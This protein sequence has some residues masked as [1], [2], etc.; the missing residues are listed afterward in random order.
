[1]K[2]KHH[3]IPKHVGGTDNLENIIELTIEEHAEAHRLLWEEHGKKEDW[4]AWQGLAGLMNKQEIV[5]E[6]LSEAGK[7]G[8]DAGKGVTGHRR[9]GALANWKKNREKLTEVL[10][11]NPKKYGHLGG[12]PENK[13]MWINNSKDEKLILIECGIPDGWK[14]GMLNMS[15]EIKDKISKTCKERGINKGI[16]RTQEHKDKLSKF[17][18]G[19]KWYHNP[20]TNESSQFTEDDKI[21]TGWI[22]GRGKINMPKRGG[23]DKDLAKEVKRR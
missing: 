2:H 1:M 18:K 3:I 6:L 23:V 5:K 13:W 15:Q 19:R 21:P 7:R 16:K 17:R 20:D 14:P 10:R 12:M 22:K 9:N 4:L 8:G 11:E